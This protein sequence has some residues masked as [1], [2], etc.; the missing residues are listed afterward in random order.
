MTPQE[1][2]LTLNLESY[3]ARLEESDGIRFIGS[4]R[5]AAGLVIESSGPPASLGETC[6]VISGGRNIPVEIIGF[7]DQMTL[8]MPLGQM[9]GIQP[10]D[11][12]ISRGRVARAPIGPELLGRVIDPT[13]EPLDGRG[14]V[15][16]RDRRPL[17]SDPVNPLARKEINEPLSTG[18]RAVD[19]CLTV[20]RGQRVG[21]FGGSGVGKSV[22]L[23][24]MARYTSAD[25]NVIALVG[26]RGREVRSFIEADLGPEGLARSVLVVATSEHSPLLR[27]R[28]ALVAT[29][30]AEHFREQGKHVLLMMDSLTRFA[31]AQR[32]VGIAAGEPPST[33]GYTPSVFSV[34]PSLVERAGLLVGGGSITGIYTVLVEGDDMN[35]PVADAARSL[36]DGH[37]LLSRRLAER[38][39]LPAIDIPASLSRLMENL[40]HPEHRAAATR[41]RALLAALNES[42][43]LIQIGAYQAGSNAEVDQALAKRAGIDAFLRQ[44]LED[45]A[46][47]DQAVEQLLRVVA[48]DGDEKQPA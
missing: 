25:V 1:P 29:A 2:E 35:D 36:L 9:V 43:D 6:E 37:I 41:L 38:G 42:E 23:A 27:I 48:T 7:R 31:M 47:I 12:L 11:R 22:L 34:L 13:G 4:V 20:G 39:H 5:R 46:T 16:C 24:M 33:K 28:A 18:V 30:I 10:G 26:E 19:G 8:S 45:A 17:T 40:S 44:R 14:P 32:E 3:F 15:R 21:I